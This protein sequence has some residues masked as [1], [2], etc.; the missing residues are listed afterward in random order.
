MRELSII[1]PYF[2]E[3]EEFIKE[4]IDSIHST[5]DVDHEIIIVDDGSVIP[6]VT[7]GARVLRHPENLGVGAAFDTAVRVADSENLFLMGCD[8][9]FI[10]NQWASLMIKEIQDNPYSLICTSVVH[11]DWG[12]TVLTF[13][14]S[15]QNFVYNGATILMAYGGKNGERDI[16]HAQ[17]L[18]RFSRF[19]EPD[20][21]TKIK[22][23]SAYGVIPSETQSYKVPCILGAAY[24]VRK[25]WY[26]YIDGFW[27][28]KKWGT[29]EPYISLK[30]WMFG[31]NCLTAPHIETAHM[32]KTTGEKDGTCLAYNAMLIAWLL[33]DS[34]DKNK[35]IDWLNHPA[36]NVALEM[37][38]KN[39]SDIYLKRKEYRN[40]VIMPLSELSQKFKLNY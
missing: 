30:S 33:F 29:L 4:T 6:L 16:L 19:V 24:G 2:N 26:Q 15:R 25:G 14:M 23:L 37:I 32:F 3:G 35:L 13:E 17:W 38:E 40:R 31:G 5:C 27:G 21:E 20:L 39:I 10:K 36:K 8:V 7:N 1:M 11:L 9:R 18:P 12:N 34:K 22:A 28:H